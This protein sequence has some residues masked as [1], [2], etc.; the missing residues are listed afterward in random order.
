M[1]PAIP[2]V[3][4]P[5]NM[6]RLN[7]LAHSTPFLVPSMEVCQGYHGQNSQEWLVLLLLPPPL[8]GCLSSILPEL[9]TSPLVCLLP[10]PSQPRFDSIT[11]TPAHPSP[12]LLW[13]GST[14]TKPLK[15]LFPRSQIIYSAANTMNT[16]WPSFYLPFQDHWTLL[17]IPSFSECSMT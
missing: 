7:L 3:S 4:L 12:F 15:L 14:P 16:S 13:S 11:L 9:Q 1:R 17:T 2:S 10:S 6:S 5:K 8:Q